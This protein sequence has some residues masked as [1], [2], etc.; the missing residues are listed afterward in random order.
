[1]TVTVNGIVREFSAD[2]ATIPEFLE[3]LELGPQPV[4]VELNGKAV[5]VREFPDH[6]ISDGDTIEVIRM[7]A[8]G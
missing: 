8:G 5:L 7:V 1:M 2:E 6:T 3:L 4:L